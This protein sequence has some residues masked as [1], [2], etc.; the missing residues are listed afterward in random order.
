MGNAM[1]CLLTGAEFDAAT[2]LRW[3]VV[4]EVLPAPQVLARATELALRTA[5]AAPLAVRATRRN[6]LLAAERGPAAASAEFVAVQAMLART[7]DAAEGV[8]AFVEKRPP[9]LSGR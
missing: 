2:A 6:A 7:G 9:R 8:R 3:N 4:Q 1:W 5:Q